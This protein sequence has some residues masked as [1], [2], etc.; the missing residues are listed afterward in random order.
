MSS[1]RERTG[2]ERTGGEPGLDEDSGTDEGESVA[3]GETTR[4]RRIEALRQARIEG[5]LEID[6]SIIADR[7]LD[8]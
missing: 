2:R 5:R 1:Q 7:L 3:S 6:P 4:R 8:S